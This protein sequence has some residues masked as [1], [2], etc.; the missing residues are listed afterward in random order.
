[1]LAMVG[2]VREM[3]LDTLYHVRESGMKICSGGIVGMGGNQSDRAGLLQ[4][5]V[6]LPVLNGQCR[7]RQLQDCNAAATG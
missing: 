2:G 1:V 6:N 5:L 3:G 4:E 7:E